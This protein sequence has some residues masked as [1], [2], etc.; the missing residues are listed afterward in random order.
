MRTGHSLLLTLLLAGCAVTP[1]AGSPAPG[2]ADAVSPG[3]AGIAVAPGV[4]LVPGRFVPGTQPD[5]NTVIL[6]GTDGLVV[7]DTGRHPEHLARVFDVL[8]GEDGEVAAIVNTHWHL[9]HAGGN[10]DLRAVYP[11][12][13]VLASD[14]VEAALGGFLADY[15][16]Q[17]QSMVGAPGDATPAQIDAWTSEIARI[18]QADALRPTR[19]LD[20][21]SEL[22][23]AGRSVRIG[24]ER[25][26]VSGGD[27]WVLDRATRTLVAGDLVTLPVPLLD[28]ACAAGWQRALAKLDALD[29]ADLVPGHGAPMDRAGFAT[30]RQA[31]D[32][33]LACAASTAPSAT[34]KAQWQADAGSLIPPADATL[35]ASLLDYYLDQVLRAPPAR[36]DRYCKAAKNR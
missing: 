20:G 11:Q 27:V 24:V 19:A 34:C 18:D 32:R 23:L 26:A 29:F 35:A 4:T 2:A 9:D 6:R 10:A 13:P 5:G 36:R 7:I 3:T 21:V 16:A 33:L 1:P 31:F 25:D 30:Y 8:R 14:A 15:R 17:L 12:V 28:T 22:A